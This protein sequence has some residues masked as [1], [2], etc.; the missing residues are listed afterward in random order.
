M[1]AT[2]RRVPEANG[3]KRDGQVAEDGEEQQEEEIIEDEE[4]SHTRPPKREEFNG[5][6]ID[7]EESIVDE[8]K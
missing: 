2:G 8:D 6:R 1:R 3:T 4:S 7:D 5:T